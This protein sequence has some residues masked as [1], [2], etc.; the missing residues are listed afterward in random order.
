MHEQNHDRD[1]G[2]NDDNRLHFDVILLLPECI[3]LLCLVLVH[4]LI[5]D[6]RE[7]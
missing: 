7:L 2:G 3:L 6:K 5:R 4:N 1:D